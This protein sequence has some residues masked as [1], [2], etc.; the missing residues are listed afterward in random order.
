MPDFE[1]LNRCIE[2][3]VA[4]TPGQRAFVCGKQVAKIAAIVAFAAISISVVS[5]CVTMSGTYVITAHDAAGN[6]LATN[7]HLVAEGTRIYTV[8]NALCATY[9]KSIVV[10]TDTKTGAELSGESPFQCR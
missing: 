9:P 6:A 7:M 3:H 8:R 5:G 1:R 10:I 4:A 2:R